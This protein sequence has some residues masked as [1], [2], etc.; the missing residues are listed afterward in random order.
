MYPNNFSLSAFIVA[1]E[2]EKK[3]KK[4]QFLAFFGK[5]CKIIKNILEGSLMVFLKVISS[6]IRRFRRFFLRSR[7]TQK[8]FWSHV[9][10]MGT[11]GSKRLIIFCIITKVEVM[12]NLICLCQT[13]FEDVCYI[14]MYQNV[15]RCVSVH[16]I[17]LPVLPRSLGWFCYSVGEWI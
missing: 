16:D 9:P 1:F 7:T 15:Q 17:S 11:Y 3:I 12:Q 8:K 4:N 14:L 10:K 5:L 13:S 2:D 6:F